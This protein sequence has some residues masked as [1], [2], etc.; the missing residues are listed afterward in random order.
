M[1]PAF[2]RRPLLAAA[3]AVLAGCSVLPTQTPQPPVV[4]PPVEPPPLVKPA[5]K[6][7]RLGLA[8]GGG[9]A[10]GFA[11]IGVIQVLEENGIKVDLVAGTSAGSLVASL[12]ASGKGGKEMQALAE[13]MDE[14]AITDWSF[15]LRGL[16]RG[17]ALA[18]FIRD[19]TGG[20]GIEQMA[21]PLGIVATDLSDGSSILFRAGD[22]GTAVRASS[23]V[24]AVFQPV[25]IGQREYVDGG[26]VSP[27]PVRFARE[28]GAQLVVAVDISSPP[29]KDPPG[30]A[31]RML[32]QTFSIMG[33][34]INTF[35]LRD[36]DVVVRPRLDGVGSADFTAR[37]R[38]IQAG[39]E[40]AQAMLPLLRQRI[41][42]KTR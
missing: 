21:L 20:K 42:E 9:A 37:R 24:P 3:L 36:A 32:M 40:A 14:G 15:P 13:T 26:L 28:M 11:H 16:I 12:Y 2:P 6:P 41:A 1:I 19:K 5:P 35:E 23:A 25:K 17:E 34:S 27:V 33:R 38:A 4:T 29:E 30:D 39:R 8:L 31:F 18:R 10:R 7:P 22:T